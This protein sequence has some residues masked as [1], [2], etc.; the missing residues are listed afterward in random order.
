MPLSHCFSRCWA[1][2]VLLLALTTSPALAQPSEPMISQSSTSQSEARMTEIAERFID[3][4]AA[5]KYEESRRLLNPRLREGWTAAQIRDDWEQ[6]Q[7][8]IGTYKDRTATHIADNNLVL[9]DLEFERAADNL[10]V[11]FDDQQQ[12]QGVDFPLQLPRL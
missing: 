9:V 4:V 8:V 10:L 2:S 3:L 6:L 12:I 7:R 1:S 11:I 5:G